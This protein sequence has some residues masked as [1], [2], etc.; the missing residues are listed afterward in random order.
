MVV[1]VSTTVEWLS[2]SVVLNGPEPYVSTVSHIQLKINNIF[3]TCIIWSP[4]TDKTRLHAYI[5]FFFFFKL[6]ALWQVQTSNGST[7]HDVELLLSVSNFSSVRRSPTMRPQQ[8]FS[9]SF[10]SCCCPPLLS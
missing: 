4:K 8:D 6:S 10:C 5:I 7:F 2:A 9:R 1:R 3:F